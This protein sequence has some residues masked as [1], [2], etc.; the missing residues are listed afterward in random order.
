LP[1]PRCKDT[2]PRG[3]RERRAVHCARSYHFV[4]AAWRAKQAKCRTRETLL[5]DHR[6]QSQQGWLELGLRFSH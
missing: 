2:Q 6:R 3:N 4:V 1:L 5:G